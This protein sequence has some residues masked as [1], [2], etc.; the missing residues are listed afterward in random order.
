VNKLVKN[1]GISVAERTSTWRNEKNPNRQF[2]HPVQIQVQIF[3]FFFKTTN[4]F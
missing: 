4:I 2:F 3:E 1:P